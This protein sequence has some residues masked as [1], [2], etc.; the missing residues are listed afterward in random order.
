MRSIIKSDFFKLRKS[1]AFW[2]CTMLCLVFGIVMVVAMQTA[3]YMAQQPVHDPDLDAMVS[4]IPNV[5]G[6]WMTGNLLSMGFNTVFIG[7]FVAIFVSSEFGFGTIKNTLSRGADRANVF[8]SKFFVCS[9]AALIMLFIFMIASMFTGTILWGFDPN[10]IVTVSGMLS[11]VL[12]Q[13]LLTIAYVAFFTFISMSMRG[14]GGAI[15]TNIMCV[16]MAS[17]L[18]SAIS[19]LFG[20]K[21]DLSHYWIGGAVSKLATVTPASGDIIQGIIIAVVWGIVAVLF[22]TALFKKQDVK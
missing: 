3:M 20:G 2:V 12:T 22:G 9:V 7:I 1:K 13:S 18:L 16:M 8:F 11:M 10:G 6:A 21:I 15:A 17:T 5:G 19:M 4:M 14:A